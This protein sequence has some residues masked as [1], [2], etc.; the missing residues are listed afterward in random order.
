MPNLLDVERWPQLRDPLMV[1]A[2][3]GWVDAG[4][5]GAGTVS[6]L[7]EQLEDADEFAT[8]DLTD[9]MDLQQTRPSAHWSDEGDRIIDWPEITFASGSLGRDLVIVSGPEPS[10]RW[11]T[12]AA[13]I[14]DVAR[15]LRVRDACTVAGMP[16][17]VSH[18]R[19]VPVLATASHHS[20]AQEIEPLR[21]AYGG[22][23]GLQTIVQR[24]LGD[25]DIRC[26]GLWAQV[27]QYVSGSPSPPA[28]RALLRRLAEIGR[29]EIDLAPL[30]A[31]CDAYATRV[32]AGLAA[33]PEV[34]EVV[35]R[36]DREQG[37]SADDLVSEIE[38]FL[39]QQPD[40]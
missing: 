38:H 10:L 24:A 22:P 13:A 23:T 29:L 36:I 26:A 33:R 12:V 15:T 39:R 21:L 27:P 14:V 30:D 25:A 28:V 2:L 19:P 16:S 18:R 11:P 17:L 4:M 9:H 20:L 40:E 1:I 5:A 7:S 31:R 6:A 32:D 37:A 3:S 35:D 8:I 34:Q